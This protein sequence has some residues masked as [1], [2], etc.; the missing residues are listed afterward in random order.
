MKVASEMDRISRVY[1]DRAVP[2]AEALMVRV[3]FSTM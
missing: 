2:V 3:F 1:P